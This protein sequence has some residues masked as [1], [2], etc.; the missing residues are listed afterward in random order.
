MPEGA[1]VRT[2]TDQLRA[3]VKDKT[4]VEVTPISG[5]LLREGIKGYRP[6][7]P[8]Q[9]LD[10]SCKGKLIYIDLADGS[11]ISS[12]L[13]MSGW[14]YPGIAPAA[15]QLAYS[16]GKGMAPSA[17]IYEQARKYARAALLMAD[18]TVAYYC[19]MRN[20]GNM[21]VWC[22]EE[23]HVP[24][25]K[26][27]IDLLQLSDYIRT[28]TWDRHTALVIDRIDASKYAKKQLAELLLAQE[29]IAGLGNI[30]RAEALYLS[31]IS[32]FAKWCD[33]TNDDKVKLLRNACLILN[34][35]YFTK[36]VMFYPANLLREN[37]HNPTGDIMGQ[38]LVY[39]RRITP[40]GE[41]VTGVDF[42]GRALWHV[43]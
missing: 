10:V 13:G 38:H 19:D 43:A 27:G 29:L 17:A 37:G 16:P 28:P 1:E 35:A 7:L 18:G 39:G 36:G 4:L 15:N 14:W 42:Q 23:A 31:R 32:P 41:Q 25:S 30:Y 40:L 5:K 26:I 6:T 2:N 34:I 22:K 24:V 20:F 21:Q 9:V 12:T 11:R 33:L 8:Q 3:L